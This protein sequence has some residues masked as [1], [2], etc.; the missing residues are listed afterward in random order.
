MVISAVPDASVALNRRLIFA[1][2]FIAACIPVFCTP[3][4][5]LIDFYNHISR[6]YLLSNLSRHPE[7]E[8][9]YQS[10]WAILPN[11]GLDVVGW[12]LFQF[13]PTKSVAR[14]IVVMIFA[15]Q[16]WGILYLN[17]AVSGRAS[18]LVAV[19]SAPLFYSYI[20]VWGFSNFLLGLGL[21]FWGA[22]FWVLKRERLKFATPLACLI[23]LIIFLVHGLAFALYGLLVLCLETGLRGRDGF[24]DRLAAARSYL[25]IAAQ[26]VAP[27]ALFALS[28]TGHASGGVTDALTNAGH[29]AAKG[30]LIGRIAEL[31]RYRL[32]TLLRVECGPTL[33]FDAVT[34]AAQ[35]AV[36]GLLAWR[37]RLTIAAGAVLSLAVAAL[38]VIV[39][40]PALFGVGYVADRMPLFLTMLFV[41]TLV[42]RWRGD[43]LERASIIALAAIVLARLA[44]TGANW[45]LYSE[46]FVQFQTVGRAIPRGSLVTD[47][48]GGASRPDSGTP[49]CEMYRPLLISLFGDVGDLF[50]NET[51]QPLRIVGPLRVALSRLPPSRGPNREPQRRTSGTMS[52]AG[53]AGFGYLMICNWSLIGTDAPV[54]G[55]LLTRTSRFE[56]FRLAAAP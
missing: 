11:V 52:A 27:V 20:L 25:A 5:P 13:L 23:A 50:A 16:Y 1:A 4:L 28:A 15:V 56:L 18:L 46:D 19:L 48:V 31:V 9:D 17:R 3:V 24:K 51:Q 26:A 43:R 41:A 30:H 42:P 39:T 47:V 53:T 10:H 2:I 55:T 36:I 29:L 34:F 14:V 22:G 6:Y 33:I 40:P 45:R 44:A 49:R 35:G 12:L 21:V 8:A 37:G 38:L 7:L 54:G 32:T